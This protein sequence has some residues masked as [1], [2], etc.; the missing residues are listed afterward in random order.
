[1][2]SMDSYQET[3]AIH[4]RSYSHQT[5]FKV[6]GSQQGRR[7]QDSVLGYKFFPIKGIPLHFVVKLIM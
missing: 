5:F 6:F 4:Q 7:N 1:M 3:D 2:L